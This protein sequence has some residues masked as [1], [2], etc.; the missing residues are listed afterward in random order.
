MTYGFLKEGMKRR[1]IKMMFNQ[2]VH[3]AHIDAMLVDPDNYNFDGESNALSVL[4]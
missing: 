2:Y 4:F 3:Q 1:A